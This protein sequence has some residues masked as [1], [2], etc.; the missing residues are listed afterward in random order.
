MRKEVLKLEDKLEKLQADMSR[1]E[2]MLDA[3]RESNKVMLGELLNGSCI[4]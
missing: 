3:M 4:F 2:A 1:K